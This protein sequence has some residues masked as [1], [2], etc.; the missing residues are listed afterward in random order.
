M[1]NLF[2]KIG[3]ILV[4]CCHKHMHVFFEYTPND[5]IEFIFCIATSRKSSAQHI[6]KHARMI[7][8][9]SQQFPVQL[10]ASTLHQSIE[11]VACCRTECNCQSTT[12]IPVG[13]K[14][15]VCT[16]FFKISQLCYKPTIS[17]KQNSCESTPS[18]I[19]QTSYRFD[20]S[21]QDPRCPHK[22]QNIRSAADR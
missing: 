17:A 4:L 21:M 6:L 9:M 15:V 19:L 16:A 20:Q 5:R 7:D 14:Y 1:T 18:P 13:R 11:H 3:K 8:G 12:D 2:D 10:A 22:A